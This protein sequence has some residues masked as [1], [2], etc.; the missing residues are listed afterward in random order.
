MKFMNIIKKFFCR[1]EYNF[2][3]DMKLDND[4]VKQLKKLRKEYGEDF[5][6]MNGFHNKNL[7]FTSFIDAFTDSSNVTDVSIDPNANCNTKDVSSL[8]FDMTKPHG[9][10]LSFNKIYYEMKK[11]YSKELAN[12]W[13]ERE[14]SGLYY[15]HNATDGSFKPYCFAYDLDDVAEKGLFFRDGMQ[16]TPANHLST[17]NM[18]LLQFVS[19]NSKL[20]TGACGIPSY[21]IYSYYFW[22][23][24]VEAGYYTVSP[25]EYRDQNFQSFIY[26]MN[27]TLLRINQ[28][29]F[30]NLSIFD[31]E[32][33]TELFGGRQFPDGTDMI[34]DMEEFMEYQKA[35]MVVA[36]D[37]KEKQ[38][39]TFPVFSYALLYEKG[40]GFVDYD[41]ARWCSDRNCDWYE[42][43]FYNGEDVSVLSNCCRLLSDMSELDAFIN[44]VGGTSLKIG[45]A[46]VNTINLRRLALEAD[47]NECLFM[48]NLHTAIG[49]SLKVMDVT[50]SILKRNV[51]KGLLPNY[52]HGLVN[53]ENQFNTIGISAMYEAMRE[54]GYIDTDEFGNK[55][56]SEN[57]LRLSGEIFEL[58]NHMR[59]N[60]EYDYQ[61]N[62]ESVPA[63][64][65]SV[66]LC[67]KDTKIFGNKFNDYIYSNQWIP[68][69]E[70]CTISEKIKLGSILDRKCGGG[71]I[72]HINLDA[73]FQTKEQAWKMLNAIAEAG[74]I[75]FA[76]NIK[77]S[78]CDK[79]HGFHGEVC[80]Q[81][82]GTAVDTYQRTVGFLRPTSDFSPE[83]RREAED[84]VW[85]P[86]DT[87][88]D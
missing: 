50:R 74:V 11:K 30:T 16:S 58:L 76:F 56:Y 73:P 48:I 80:P 83:K 40:K 36:G 54:F 87:L 60:N 15:F 4:F 27:Q 63:E 88:L 41:F 82:G 6:K 37:I 42:S 17:F 10:L 7:N 44:S 77:I 84:K 85:Y 28:S 21:L 38:M 29:A 52:T 22:K 57:A 24:D 59:K 64:T 55:S 20:Q 25:E 39:F 47:G 75:Y 23:K 45:S 78:I 34:D 12:M 35:F 69:T 72:A 2:S 14:Y 33:Y 61:I 65:A 86:T 49:L 5:E 9:K 1:N 26:N 81:C 31:R 8:K 3:I 71:S 46:V 66:V 67:N 53:F 51:E 32:Y 62:V 68:L 43:N 70:Q 19:Y 13:L 79:G 18:H